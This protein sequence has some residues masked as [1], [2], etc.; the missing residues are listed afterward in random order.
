MI[1]SGERSSRH[2]ANLDAPTRRGGICYRCDINKLDWSVDSRLSMDSLLLEPR[3]I[4]ILETILETGNRI[5][6]TSKRIVFWG[7]TP[8]PIS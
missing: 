6:K 7:G 5:A 3:R 1:Q 4:T 2:K 8:S